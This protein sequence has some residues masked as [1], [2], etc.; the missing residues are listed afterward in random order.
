MDL[1][2]YG[3]YNDYEFDEPSKKGKVGLILKILIFV[4][5]FSV[6]GVLLFRVFL[7]NHY[8]DKIENLYF[9]DTL[10]EYYN[11]TDG[12]IGAKTQELRFPYDDSSK[13]RF[14]GDHLVVI[15]AIGQLQVSLR[16]NDSLKDTVKEELKIDID[17]S[18][19]SLF[20]FRLVRNPL[21][22]EE[23][24]EPLEIGTLSYS[25]YDSF[26][27]Y[28]YYKL[29]FDGIDFSGNG[30]EIK[31]L[32]LEILVNGVEM[33]EPYMILIY[34]NNEAFSAFEDYKPSAKEKP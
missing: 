32:R 29:V 28:N 31:W 20:T 10:T 22:E 15:D 18:D 3:D 2:R 16:Y 13:G 34:E 6:V 24:A 8:P 1:E 23:G 25:E 12:N 26:M 11:E 4:V 17:P 27:M 19:T 21:T 33:K 14:F 9:N 30:S 7:F 5:C